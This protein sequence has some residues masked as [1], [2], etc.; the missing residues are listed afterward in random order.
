VGASCLFSLPWCSCDSP[1]AIQ[2]RQ[3]FPSLPSLP[4]K[5]M[6]GNLSDRTINER[7]K[8]LQEYVD[9][10]VSSKAIITSDSVLYFLQVVEHRPLLLF[11]D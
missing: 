3:S 8:A 9:F 6:W 2:L 1:N 10:V 4:E 7:K 5:K 11:H